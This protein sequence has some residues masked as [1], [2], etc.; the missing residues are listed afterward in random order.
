MAKVYTC[1]HFFGT[2]GI[3]EGREG[4]KKKVWREIEW[5][6]RRSEGRDGWMEE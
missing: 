3:A 6:R 2:P 1:T 4:G 5:E